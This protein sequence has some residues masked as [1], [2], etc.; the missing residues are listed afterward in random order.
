MLIM[1]RFFSQY[2]PFLPIFNTTI[3]PNQCFTQSPFLSWVIVYVGS[4]SYAGDPTLLERLTPKI[5][6]MAFAALETRSSPI[7]T[8]Q[9]ILLLCQWPTPVETMHRGIS[10]VLA[11][12]A[13]HLAM[14][15]GLHVRG[16]GQDFARTMLDR[17]RFDRDNRSMLWKQC[18]T[19]CYM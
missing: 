19:T 17:N 11:G 18:C 7:Q 14:Q 4:R 1:S 8:I 15:I 9:G 16:V 10:L 2:A 3:S 13:L 12:A 5:N 6:S